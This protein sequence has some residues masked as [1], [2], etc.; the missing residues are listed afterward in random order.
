MELKKR[1]ELAYHE[2]DTAFFDLESQFKS[3]GAVSQLEGVK[4]KLNQWEM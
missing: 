4:Q 2:L 3:Q 1:K